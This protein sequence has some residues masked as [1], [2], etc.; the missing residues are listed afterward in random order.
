MVEYD[1]N[2]LD[3]FSDEFWEDIEENHVK[4]IEPEGR[5]EHKK[6]IGYLL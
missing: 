2:K 3:F 1:L 4:I 5:W 6:N